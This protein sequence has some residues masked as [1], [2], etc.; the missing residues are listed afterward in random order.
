MSHRGAREER[1]TSAF[2]G[3]GGES[4]NLGIWEPAGFVRHCL[5]GL[6]E[7]RAARQTA[8]PRL[9]NEVRNR[10]ITHPPLSQLCSRSMERSEGH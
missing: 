8:L 5:G 9:S 1:E 7:G 10:T 4:R 3:L 6:Q 2:K